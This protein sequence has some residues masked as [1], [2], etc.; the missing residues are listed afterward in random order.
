MCPTYLTCAL[1]RARFCASETM[2]GMP[3]CNAT[4][5]PANGNEPSL[6]SGCGGNATSRWRLG[7]SNA[8]AGWKRMAEAVLRMLEL[9]ILRTCRDGGGGLGGE[10]G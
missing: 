5:A 7:G 9:E 4:P 6:I 3:T 2:H 10:G 1:K 8:E